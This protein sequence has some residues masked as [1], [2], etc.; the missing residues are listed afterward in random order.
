MPA[1]R[2]Q[3]AAGGGIAPWQAQLAQRLHYERTLQVPWMRNRQMCRTH[4]VRA[5]KDQVEVD[6]PRRVAA[7]AA[8]TEARFD[9]LEKP[10]ELSR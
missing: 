8:T 4:Q 7:H 9:L 5:V 3:R 10:K 2:I 1:L 6:R